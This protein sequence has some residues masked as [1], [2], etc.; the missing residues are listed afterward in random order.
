MIQGMKAIYKKFKS[1]PST[2]EI[3]KFIQTKDWLK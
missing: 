2:Q 3:R 1:I